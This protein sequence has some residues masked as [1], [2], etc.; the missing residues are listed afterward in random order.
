VRNQRPA[1]GEK[2]QEPFSEYGPHGPKKPCGFPLRAWR[3]FSAQPPAPALSDEQRE[4]LNEIAQIV[5]DYGPES[6]A[7]GDAAFLRTL[8]SQEQGDEDEQLAEEG[9][10]AGYEALQIEEAEHLE[11]PEGEIAVSEPLV[12]ARHAATIT[13]LDLLIEEARSQSRTAGSY[14]LNEHDFRRLEEIVENAKREATEH[15]EDL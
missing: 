14:R 2:C 11:R 7:A 13:A 3:C 10:A 6:R 5:Q 12:S 15:G 8:A 4:H 1:E 9:M